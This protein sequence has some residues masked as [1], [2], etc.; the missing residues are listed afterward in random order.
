MTETITALPQ[1]NLTFETD[2]IN[3]LAR[4]DAARFDKQFAGFIYLGGTAPISASLSHTVAALEAFVHGYYVQQ[5]PT[6]ITYIANRRTYVFVDSVETRSPEVVASGG[7]GATFK[8][9]SGNLVVIE[10]DIGSSQP[11][12]SIPGLVPLFYVNS[13]PTEI[14]AVVDLRNLSPI[15]SSTKTI[16]PERYGL[17]GDNLTDNLISFQAMVNALPG[18]S[19]IHFGQ[20]IYRFSGKIVIPKTCIVEGTGNSQLGTVLRITSATQDAIEITSTE[21]VILRNLVLD[22][23]IIR[24]GGSGLLVSGNAILHRV[25]NITFDGHQTQIK[26]NSG[27]GWSVIG[28]NFL[29]TSLVDID[30]QSNV[31][32][33]DVDALISGNIFATSILALPGTQGVKISK[34]IGLT[35]TNNRFVGYNN[36]IL[37]DPTV[38]C[39]SIIINQNTFRGQDASGIVLLRSGGSSTLHEFEISNNIIVGAGLYGILVQ[40]SAPD[41]FSKGVIS[42]NIISTAGANVIGIQLNGDGGMLVEGNNINLPG[43]SSVCINI[44][45]NSNA[46]NIG[47][48]GYL[49]ATFLL[50]AGTNV[51]VAPYPVPFVI[52]IDPPSIAGVTQVEVITALAGARTTDLVVIGRP[53]PASLPTTIAYCGAAIHTAGFLSVY[54]LNSSG[55]AVNPGLATWIGYLLRTPA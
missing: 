5:P 39:N 50:Y 41:V 2:T 42:G 35:I 24:T 48:N 33:P 8:S 23:S 25:E 14:D 3:F 27:R 51:I 52:D 28:C 38:D 22:S 34:A 9:R 43:A 40:A 44:M 47:H 21:Q 1:N 18:G 12:L 15:V 53:P 16:D 29:N 17:V 45:A 36:G 55:G 46:A 37:I 6:L 4:E 11:T 31:V 54:L 49:G 13:D 20:G 26:F 10:C 30:I 19:I 32:A 7:A